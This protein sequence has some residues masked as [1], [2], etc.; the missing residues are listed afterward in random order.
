MWLIN[1][2]DADMAKLLG[3]L[4]MGLDDC[5]PRDTS[6][7]N[8][9]GMDSSMM[10]G[11]NPNIR[12]NIMSDDDY[13]RDNSRMDGGPSNIDNRGG[14]KSQIA[15]G[16]RNQAVPIMLGLGAAAAGMSQQDDM[17]TDERVVSKS[18]DNQARLVFSVSFKF[19]S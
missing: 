1:V 2:S 6:N 18:N 13:M 8:N 11:P 3:A 4:E 9:R 5:G 15:D 19:L 7:R 17:P 10:G 14:L 16:I 12:N